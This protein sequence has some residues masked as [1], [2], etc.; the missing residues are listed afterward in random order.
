[1][2]IQEVKAMKVD[3]SEAELKDAS[4][5]MDQEIKKVMKEYALIQMQNLPKIQTEKAKIATIADHV[6]SPMDYNKSL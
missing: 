2:I 6:E 4:K 3:L 1:M 5:T